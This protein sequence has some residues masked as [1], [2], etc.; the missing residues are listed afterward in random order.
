[1]DTEAFWRVLDAANDGDNPLAVADYLSA[2][3]LHGSEHPRV[4][5]ADAISDSVTS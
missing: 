3:P 4:G 1:M 5:G 2:L